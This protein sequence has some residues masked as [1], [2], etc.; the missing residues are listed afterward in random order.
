MEKAK[1]SNYFK[2][3]YKKKPE[4]SKNQHFIKLLEN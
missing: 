3:I 2:K 4:I 1:I